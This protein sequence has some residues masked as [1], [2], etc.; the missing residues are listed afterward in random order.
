MQTI[1]DFFPYDKSRPGQTKVLDWIQANWSKYDVFVLQCP[2]A[3]GK[4]GL[5]VT[6]ARW[7]HEMFGMLSGICTPDNV[8][9]NQYRKDFNLPYLPM[10]RSFASREHYIMAREE[11][12]K[13]PI[14][15]MNYFT[16]LANRAYS[17]VQI[18]D[19]AHQLIPT[20]QDFEGVKVWNHLEP[21]PQSIRTVADVLLWAASRGPADQLGRKITKLLAKNPKNYVVAHETEM[22]RGHMRDRLRVYPLSP[23]DNRPIL[24]P[25]SRVSKLILMSA[26]IAKPDIDDLGLTRRRVGYVEVPSDIP[27]KNRPFVYQGVAH[28]GKRRT[29]SDITRMYNQLTDIHTRNNGRGFIH[30]TY[31]LASQIPKDAKFIKHHIADKKSLL[32]QWITDKKDRRSFVGCGL[33][34]GLDLAGPNFGWQAIIKCQFPDLADPAVLAKANMDPEWYAWQAIRQIAQA[35]G[36]VCRGPEDYGSTFMLDSDF[37]MLYSRHRHL[38][39]K[40]L[41]EAMEVS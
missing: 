26:T 14:K 17:D 27:K 29:K 19:E 18:M 30:S 12:K 33:T 1:H 3:A 25:P 40:W 39:P 37:I 7:A 10:A 2:V 38:F 35:Y 13:E 16:L 4:S 15:V 31:E 23:K 21:Y 32:D 20:L 36:R 6:I 41:T 24:W 28:M 22:Y 34:T 9:V 5:A 11:F 8:L